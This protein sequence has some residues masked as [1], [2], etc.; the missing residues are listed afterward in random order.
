MVV[1]PV[2]APVAAAVRPVAAIPETD[3][4]DADGGGL[5]DDEVLAD[6]LMTEAEVEA[7]VRR[8]VRE[9]LQGP[10]GQQISRKVKRLIKEEIRKAL[11][12]DDS[13]I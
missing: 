13:L 2:P 11:Y 4:D 1:E 8:V 9:E 12:E 10:I 5:L 3:A 6:P 7:I